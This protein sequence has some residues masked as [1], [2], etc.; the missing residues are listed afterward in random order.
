MTYIVSA[1]PDLYSTGVVK[2]TATVTPPANLRDA[3]P[4]DNT[5]SDIDTLVP[6]TNLHV[7]VTDGVTSATS[8]ACA[9]LYRHG[10]QLLVGRCRRRFVYRCTIGRGCHQRLYGEW[11]GWLHGLGHR[12]WFIYR[13]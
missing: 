13:Q 2:L 10:R 8:G 3:N 11:H 12:A 9:G 6:S 4:A 1:Y 5:A 7:E